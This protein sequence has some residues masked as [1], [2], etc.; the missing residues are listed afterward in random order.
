M[1]EK[2]QCRVC[3]EEKPM[4]DYYKSIY[5]KSGKMTICKKCY[6]EKQKEIKSTPQNIQKR[7]EYNFKNKERIKEYNKTYYCKLR[8]NKEN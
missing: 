1:S 6:L 8:S 5:N 7:K 4:D 2:Q 3:G